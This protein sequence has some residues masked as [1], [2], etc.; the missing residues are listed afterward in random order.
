MLAPGD[1]YWRIASR[2][3]SDDGGS[4]SDARSFT[5]KPIPAAP[6]LSPPHIDSKQITSQWSAGDAGYKYQFQL[7]R[8]EGF[9]DVLADQTLSEPKITLANPG[10]GNYFMRVKAID[11]DGFAGS[12]GAPQ[13]MQ[14]PYN[15]PWWLAIPV[16]LFVLML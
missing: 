11:A 2:I 9:H 3:G 8:D 14:I 6:I 12:F 13:Q 4:F 16:L 1:Y 7:A 15:K 10:A 5:L